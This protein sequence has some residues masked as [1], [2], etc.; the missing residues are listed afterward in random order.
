V[1]SAG[2]DVV[3]DEDDDDDEDNDDISRFFLFDLSFLLI[4]KLSH[5]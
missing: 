5:G 1:P 4:A 3:G 2:V